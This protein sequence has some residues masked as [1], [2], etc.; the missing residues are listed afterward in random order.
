[1]NVLFCQYVQSSFS[2][3]GYQG[4]SLCWMFRKAKIAWKWLLWVSTQYLIAH[5]SSWQDLDSVKIFSCRWLIGVFI[6]DWK[7][8]EDWEPLVK[9]RGIERSYLKPLV[10]SYA[11]GASRAGCPV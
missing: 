3:G 7:S 5:D 2:L 8:Y 11:P 9:Q 1:M 6:Q 4:A 10:Q